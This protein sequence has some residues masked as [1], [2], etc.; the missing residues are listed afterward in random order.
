MKITFSGTVNIKYQKRQQYQWF[1]SKF[2]YLP[3]KRLSK[4]YTGSRISQKIR[5]KV[6]KILKLKKKKNIDFP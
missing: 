6:L 5:K 4:I 2:L 1:F 3:L